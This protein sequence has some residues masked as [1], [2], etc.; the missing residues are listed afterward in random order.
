VVHNVRETGPPECSG[1]VAWRKGKR[2]NGVN[3]PRERELLGY[4]DLVLEGLHR[5]KAEAAASSQIS[6]T[7]LP[8]APEDEGSCMFPMHVA[9]FYALRYLAW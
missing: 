5:R 6:R 4:L 9:E 8:W 3:S 7:F 2:M 1:F